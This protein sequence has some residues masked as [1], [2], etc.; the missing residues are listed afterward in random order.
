M[1]TSTLS[2]SATRPATQ[3]G[4]SSGFAPT[5]ITTTCSIQ[6]ENVVSEPHSPVRS[7]I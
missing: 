5:S 7:P 4:R 2:A 3:R 6:L 1:H